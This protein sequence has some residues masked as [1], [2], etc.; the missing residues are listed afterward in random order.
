MDLVA[1]ILEENVAMNG[2]ETSTT[3]LRQSGWS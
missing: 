2:Q 1:M 3:N